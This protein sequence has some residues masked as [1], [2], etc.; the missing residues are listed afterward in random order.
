LTRQD[1]LVLIIAMLLAA[2]TGWGAAWT[3]RAMGRTGLEAFVAAVAAAVSA[4]G[5]FFLA[6]STYTG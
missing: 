3:T 6:R 4:M 5:L 1:V 2:H